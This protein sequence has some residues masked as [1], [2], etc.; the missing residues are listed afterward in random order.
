MKN[1]T[2]HFKKSAR[3]CIKVPHKSLY[4]SNKLL[5][6][7]CN[8]VYA[9][10]GKEIKKY[11]CN[12]ISGKKFP[13]Y[14]LNFRFRVPYNNILIKIFELIYIYYFFILQFVVVMTQV[15]Q[16]SSGN[17]TESSGG[18]QVPTAGD[19]VT[20]P[21]AAITNN[22]K[23]LCNEYINAPTICNSNEL[24]GMLG[25]FIF[26]TLISL[27]FGIFR[28]C[29]FRCKTCCIYGTRSSRRKRMEEE[30]QENDMFEK[31]MSSLQMRKQLLTRQQKSLQ[32][33]MQGPQA[34][35]KGKKKK[36][37]SSKK[38]PENLT[39][40]LSVGYMPVSQ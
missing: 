11:N 31:Q 39:N 26:S 29:I 8:W 24:M 20:D 28:T 16:M 3:E 32:A 13:P 37:K 2:N 21:Q 36:K 9:E 23:N 40:V 5:Y 7:N 19:V 14:L 6:L 10:E 30:R 17:G 1:Q 15:T 33:L 38:E 27:I 4:Y 18:V 25:F 12:F 34:Q 35:G 22:I